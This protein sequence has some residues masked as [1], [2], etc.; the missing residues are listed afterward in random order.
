MS[1]LRD[2]QAA[3]DGG[4]PTTTTGLPP[5]T[6]GNTLR[7]ALKT[8]DLRNWT[9]TAPVLLCAGNGDPA[10]LYL[11]TQFMQGYWAQNAPPNSSITIL[12]VDSAFSRGDP[13][14][15]LKARFAV[16]KAL[17]AFAAVIRGA[18]DGGA[19]AVLQAYH[20]ALVPPFCVS[21]AKS[22][23]DSH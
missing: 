18:R 21:A 8:N 19:S 15:D 1:Y 4:F 16:V 9:P 5:T 12:D 22:F 13:Y 20:T 23:F 14:S 6:P 17:V 2:A 10:V 11:N 7:Q 3:P